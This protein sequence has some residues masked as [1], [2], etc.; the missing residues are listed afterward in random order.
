MSNQHKRESYE[1]GRRAYAE[2]ECRPTQS[3]IYDLRSMRAGWDDCDR[4]AVA[5]DDIDISVDLPV[6]AAPTPIQRVAAIREFLASLDA[7]RSSDDDSF[8]IDRLQCAIGTL[9]G[10]NVARA[11]GLT[12]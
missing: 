4:G 6:K 1:A 11:C 3:A 9:D 12:V 8:A 2:G 7:S 5:C 10:A